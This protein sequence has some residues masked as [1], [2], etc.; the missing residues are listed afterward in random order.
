[1]II[2]D[3]EPESGGGDPPEEARPDADN[4]N[5]TYN[6]FCHAIQTKDLKYLRAAC[7]S[8]ILGSD[9]DVRPAEWIQLAD[10]LL[11]Y[12]DTGAGAR[13]TLQTVSGQPEKF[14]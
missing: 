4:F 6:A 12:I 13:P 10:A 9:M 2:A 14:R 11:K 8:V 1:M 7:V 3:E 5:F